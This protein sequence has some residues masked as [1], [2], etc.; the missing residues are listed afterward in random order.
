[1]TEIEMNKYR[2]IVNEVKKISDEYETQMRNLSPVSNLK[3]VP[4]EKSKKYYKFRTQIIALGGKLKASLKRQVKFL[5]DELNH[6]YVKELSKCISTSQLISKKAIDHI[7]LK[8]SGVKLDEYKFLYTHFIKDCEKH[9]EIVKMLQKSD[10]SFNYLSKNTEKIISMRA[11]YSI[12][13]LFEEDGVLKYDSIFELAWEG[14][15]IGK[16]VFFGG[17][18][19]LLKNSVKILG[20]TEVRQKID[21]KKVKEIIRVRYYRYKRKLK[22][23]NML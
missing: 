11:F 21:R 17:D 9:N 2:N 22:Q 15:F 4:S 18:N 16:S 1:M 20:C 5:Q 10:N 12:C 13:Q 8:R 19:F 23:Q 7:K 3:Q 6:V 14:S